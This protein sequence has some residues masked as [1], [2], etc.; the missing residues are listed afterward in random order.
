MSAAVGKD[1]KV[2]RPI[3]QPASQFSKAT[4]LVEASERRD[5]GDT[6]RCELSFKGHKGFV[7]SA[8]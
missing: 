7:D 2:D 8:S 5:F 3:H 6:A 4:A 1:F